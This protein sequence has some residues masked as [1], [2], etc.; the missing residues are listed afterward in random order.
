M[1][2]V[3]RSTSRAPHD[4]TTGR[5]LAETPESKDEEQRGEAKLRQ[6][7]EMSSK[8]T[9]RQVA[10]VDDVVTNRDGT[11]LALG[12]DCRTEVEHKQRHVGDGGLVLGDV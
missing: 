12:R 8:S 11:Q 4:N 7:S 3:L 2:S 6:R 5:R 1:W 10:E 9:V